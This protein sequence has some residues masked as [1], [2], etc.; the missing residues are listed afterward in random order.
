[1]V[2]ERKYKKRIY[3]VLKDQVSSFK[4]PQS[5]GELMLDPWNEKLLEVYNDL[6]RE[7]FRLFADATHR[8]L[9]KQARKFLTMGRNEEW[10][11]EVLEF[12]S[13]EGLRMVTTISGNTRDLLLKVVNEAIQQGVNEGMGAEEVA[14]L[15]EARLRDEGYTY[16]RYRAERIARTETIRAANMGHMAGAKSLEFEVSKVWISAKDHRTRRIPDDEWDH[17]RMDG[18]TVDFEEP[19]TSTSKRGVQ[20]GANQPGDAKAPA[21]FTI[22]CRCR[23]AFEPKRD[24]DGRLIRKR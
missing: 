22:N 3:K 20:I 10:T 7:T 21:G 9:N 4:Y 12:L 8:S 24:G 19:F 13:R 23:V 15:V 6:Y 18:Q 1:M 16:T 11:R 5:V 2:L 14:R 17:W